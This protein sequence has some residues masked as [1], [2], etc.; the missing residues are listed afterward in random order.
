MNE[1]TKTSI[2]GIP[3]GVVDDIV[4]GMPK[5]ETKTPT[6]ETSD[7]QVRGRVSIINKEANHADSMKIIEDAD[8]RPMTV[9]EALLLIDKDPELKEK[10]KGKWFYLDGKGFKEESGYYKFDSN[11]DLSKGKGNPEQTLYAY[12]G[13]N[14][15]SLLV[16]DGADVDY[17]RFL[18]DASYDP[19]DVAP[20]VVGLKKGRPAEGE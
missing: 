9:G 4:R 15:L 10:L 12:S 13:S 3:K 17:G 7:V 16:R 5:V 6:K 1:K 18:L 8:L 2:A 11:G 19:S 14:P 20:V